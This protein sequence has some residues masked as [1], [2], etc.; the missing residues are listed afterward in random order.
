VPDTGNAENNGS[1]AA[2]QAQGIRPRQDSAA[3]PSE[4]EIAERD[5]ER[6]KQNRE[7]FIKR[8]FRRLVLCLDR[9]NGIVT[10]FATAAIA[11]LTISLSIDSSRQAEMARGQFEIMRGQLEEAKNQRLAT[12][13]QL[14]ANLRR[15]QINMHPVN[16]AGKYAIPGEEMIGWD[17]NPNWFNAATTDAKSYIAWFEIDVLPMPPIVANTVNVD[18]PVPLKPA[19]KIAS[20]VFS[21]GGRKVEV[22]KRLSIED[23]KA[24]AVEPPSKVIYI[25]GHAEYTDIFFPETPQHHVDWCVL[26]LPHVYQ[27]N[28]F[29]FLIIREDTD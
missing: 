4:R 15:E 20:S 12:I 26:A 25:A 1:A 8:P 7:R 11:G 28:E 13:A 16:K 27:R 24:A 5:N 6:A 2:E 10:A 19:L 9:Y 22:A 29:S 23:V 14:R 21:A 17:V 3:A 18:C